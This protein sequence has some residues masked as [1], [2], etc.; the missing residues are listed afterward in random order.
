MHG[1]DLGFV[2]IH[3]SVIYTYIKYLYRR[4]TFQL[5]FILCLGFIDCEIRVSEETKNNF[6]EVAREVKDTIN[7]H[8]EDKK[9]LQ[10]NRFLNKIDVKKF[11]DLASKN[12]S[13]LRYDYNTVYF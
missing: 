1:W 7:S 11:A 9:P 5:W 6:W 13:V 3:S 2:I 4:S 8:L 10:Y 12:N